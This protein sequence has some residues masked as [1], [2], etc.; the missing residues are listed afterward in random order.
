VLA[1]QRLFPSLHS[2]VLLGAC[3]GAGVSSAALTALEEAARRKVPSLG[4]NVPYAVG[5]VLLTLAGPLLV[6]LIP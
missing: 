5:N 2:G 4:Y 3:A 1:G 6:A